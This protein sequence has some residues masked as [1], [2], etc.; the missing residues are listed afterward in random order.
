MRFSIF[1][2]SISKIKAAFDPQKRERLSSQGLLAANFRYKKSALSFAS[3][4]IILFLILYSNIS[5]QA[6]E[7]IPNY[8][9]STIS[10][11]NNELRRLNGDASTASALL[12]ALN[13]TVSTLVPK[14]VIA[15]WSGSVASIP[16]GWHL[17]DGTAGTPDLRNRFI[18]AADAD[19][20]GI[21]ESTVTGVPT[22]SGDGSVPAVSINT[23][24]AGNDPLTWHQGSGSAGQPWYTSEPA[25]GTVG[26]KLNDLGFVDG[27]AGKLAEVRPKAHTHTVSFGTGTKNIAVYFS[28]AYIMKI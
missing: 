10:V 25:I 17:C 14:G 27:T 8:D 7:T 16:S 11:L 5:A 2:N 18:V 23:G 4:I 3:I 1:H 9:N 20:G 6:Q 13:T 21:A 15:M 28:L 24:S 12:V 19:V 22:Q 26:A